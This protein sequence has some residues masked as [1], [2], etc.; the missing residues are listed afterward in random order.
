MRET[1]TIKRYFP[2]R[3][4]GFIARHGQT[5]L[6]FHISDSRGVPED[7]FVEGAN[8]EYSVVADEG[9][10]RAEK[11]AG[12][13]PLEDLPTDADLASVVAAE[14]ARQLQALIDCGTIRPGGAA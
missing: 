13:A 14:V 10:M 9:G 1:G 2:D 11:G 12:V 5:D 3:G 7:S 8:V 4:F 6:F